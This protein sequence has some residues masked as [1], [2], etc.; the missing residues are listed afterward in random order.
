VIF[1]RQTYDEMSRDDDEDPA[2]V[3]AYEVD[4]V[5]LGSHLD[6]YSVCKPVFQILRL[7]HKYGKPAPMAHL[8]LEVF[9][10]IENKVFEVHLAA[11]MPQWEQDYSCFR[12]EC[13][14]TDH[15]APWEIENFIDIIK[16][17]E[18][19][20]LKQLDSIM[21]R[22]GTHE[23]RHNNFR[24]SW[25]CKLDPLGGLPPRVNYIGHTKFVS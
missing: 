10:M 5:K 22:Y 17:S 19:E 3:W 11:L 15:Y 1:P 4:P 12:E 13:R 20:P 7:C 25:R 24:Y 21:D 9:K 16:I 6:T 14:P 2:M 18:P 8:P 23:F